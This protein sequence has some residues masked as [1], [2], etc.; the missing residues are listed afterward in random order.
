MKSATAGG[1]G[2]LM[3]IGKHCYQCSQIDYCPFTCPHC[4]NIYCLS[5]RLVDDHSCQ[6]RPSG[7]VVTAVL[8][9][10][11]RKQR[12]RQLNPYKCFV[13]GC[14]RR[15]IY[16]NKCRKC[17]RHTCWKHHLEFDHKC[18]DD[19]DDDDV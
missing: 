2:G 12:H 11:E 7:R 18:R 16:E 13:R 3:E 15:D 8:S 17:Q 5:C 10:A 19:D 1:G 14:R 6:K 9:E 4:A